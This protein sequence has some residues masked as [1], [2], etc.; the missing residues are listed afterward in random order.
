MTATGAKRCP[1]A[2]G[3]EEA[4]SA[5]RSGEAQVYRRLTG[6]G[7]GGSKRGVK[8]LAAFQKATRENTTNQE[9]MIAMCAPRQNGDQSRRYCIL[10]SD[11]VQEGSA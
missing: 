6:P 4:S 2:S 1:D 9:P 11:G 7:L 10:W 5:S 3:I 8:G